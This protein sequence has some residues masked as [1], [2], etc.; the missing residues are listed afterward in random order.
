MDFS[1]GNLTITKTDNSS[2]VYVLSELRYLSFEDF[3]TGI[4]ES[5][6]NENQHQN[7]KTYPNPVISVFYVDL[8]GTVNQ[9]G[10]IYIIN[11]YG[12]VEKIQPVIGKGV[13]SVDIGQL[14]NGIYLCRYSSGKEISTVKIIKQ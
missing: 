1:S 7:I 4:N 3:V 11:L 14:P 8:S 12:R 6:I 5:G 10:I 2:G 9:A 13:V